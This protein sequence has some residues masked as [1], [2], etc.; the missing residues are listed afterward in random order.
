MPRPSNFGKDTGLQVRM[1]MTLFLLGLVYA[2]LVGI[3]VASGYMALLIVVGG[4]LALQ[5]FASDKLALHAMGAREVSPQEAP[6]LHAMVERLCVQANLPKPRVAVAN[7]PM[8][9]AFAIGRSPKKA[10]VCAT[11][12][13][14]DLLSP[15]ELEGVMAHELTHVQNRDVMVMTI[16]GFFAAIASYI[17]QFGF[18]FGGGSSDDDDGPGFMVVILVSVVVYIISFLLL[19][20]LSRYREFAA[21]RGAAII[22]GRPSAL[23]SALM[24]I[25]GTMDRIPQRDLRASEELAAFYIF[26]PHAKN[27]LM[28]LFSTHP[29]M[30]KRIAALSRLESQL[31]G[32]A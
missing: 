16:A 21:D 24:R 6:Q 29:P 18:F 11:T 31:Q 1:T 25:S 13:I 15:A 7:T 12:G 23:S 9:N 26:P 5:F 27:S 22:T 4:L 32:S 8:P 17:V 30:E 14:M 19:Q 2:V 28:G 10:T 3:V 20:A